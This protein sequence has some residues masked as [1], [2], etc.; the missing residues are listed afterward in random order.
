MA[1]VMTGNRRGNGW[2]L[3]LWPGAG[4][5]LLAPAVAMQF[6]TEV[7]WDITDFLVMGALIAAVGGAIEFL[8]RRSNSPAYRAGAALT[9]VTA[10][11]LIWVNLA[12][13]LIGTE[14]H[15]ANLL[16][17][18]VFA[19]LAGG[20]L[21]SHFRPAGMMRTLVAAAAAQAAIGAA[22]VLAGWGMEGQNWPRDVIGANGMF[23]ALWL[24]SAALFG[25]AA[26]V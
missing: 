10:F 21:M 6:T 15:R 24:A 1:E 17:A 3:A 25:R 16:Y 4:A 11:L 5:L 26:R 14:D 22:A 20:A 12:A 8:V 13:G 9:L 18:G 23:A 2:R 7:K 19:I